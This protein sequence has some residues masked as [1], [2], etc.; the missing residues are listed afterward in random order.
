MS[1]RI[2]VHDLDNRSV[3]ELRAICNRGWTL[4]GSPSVESGGDTKIILDSVSA[5][6]PWMQLGRVVTIHHPK[7][8]VW[9]GVL[10]TPWEA[11]LPVSAALYN[12]E[13]LFSLRTPDSTVMMT[14]S[15]GNIVAQMVQMMNA[16][17]E[18]YL[19]MGVVDDDVSRQETLD[20][21]PFWEQVKALVE[22][23]GME[24]QI[25]PVREE[26]RLFLYVDILGRVGVDTGFLFHDGEKANMTV[27]SA[28]VDGEIW[29]RVI[30]LGDE[31]T[32][33]GRSQ[34]PALYE[35]NSIR[36]YRLR[37]SN[38]QFQGVRDVS[39]LR[40]YTLS[41]VEAMSRPSLKLKVTIN[42]V[43]DALRY[44]GVGNTAIFHAHNIYLPAGRVGW[45]GVGRMTAIAYDEKSN[46][47]GLLIEAAL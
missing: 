22:R 19:R 6:K 5:S 27:K 17:E 23:A 10:D 1:S 18:T 47:V 8:P 26:N 35:P 46:T 45:K 30:G 36:D 29:N 14:G 7:L 3:G 11:Q 37:S 41:Y 42:D 25:R 43:G 21:R 33:A 12:I 28:T 34:T 2:V 31:S 39:T 15:T 32:Q 38:V 16:Q 44:V 4:I 24:M 9:A 13:Y 40:N 20:A